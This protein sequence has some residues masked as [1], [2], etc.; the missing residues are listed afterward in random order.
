M[1][2]MF[3]ITEQLATHG[4]GEK[5]YPLKYVDC[6]VGEIDGFQIIDV[7]PLLDESGNSDADY[8][9]NISRVTS[10]LENGKK[11]VICCGAGISRSNGVAL[12]VLVK[13]FKMDYYD[14][15][16]LIRDKVPIAQI[17]PAH[18]DAAKRIFKVPPPL[19]L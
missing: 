4:I 18:L 9:L 7:R 5:Y 12:M 1:M 10:Y 16:E 17:E 11:V 3:R 2:F 6:E 19:V 8:K 14:A 13:Y 15:L